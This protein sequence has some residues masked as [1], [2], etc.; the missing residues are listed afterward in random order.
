MR[1]PAVLACGALI[2][3]VAAGGRAFVQPLLL[4]TVLLAP[5][6]LPRRFLYPT[7]GGP[8][9]DESD[10]DDGGGRG[11][12]PEP[13]RPPTAPRGG[14]P[15]PDARPARIRL[16][17]HGRPVLTPRRARRAVREPDRSPKRPRVSRGRQAVGDG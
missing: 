10:G 1:L 9:A 15:L 13:P 4:L 5:A 12:H 2:G 7:D 11:P 17:D 14:L 3:N 6:F 16:R 8:P